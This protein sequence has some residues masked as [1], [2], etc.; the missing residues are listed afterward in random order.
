VFEQEL[1]HQVCHHP[2]RLFGEHPPSRGRPSGARWLR[3]TEQVE[4]MDLPVVVRRTVTSA[5]HGHPPGSG[6]EAPLLCQK[7]EYSMT[8]SGRYI[9]LPRRSMPA[10]PITRQDPHADRVRSPSAGMPPDRTSRPAA[11][12]SAPSLRHPENSVHYRCVKCW[13]MTAAHCGPALVPSPLP[14]R[15]GCICEGCDNPGCRRGGCQGRKP[16]APKAS[17]RNMVTARA[18]PIPIPWI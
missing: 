16:T 18:D 10:A 11:P 8:I 17:P 5:S 4:L 3:R 6:C 15:E 12:A 13:A 1:R 14:Q 9:S 7:P 2:T